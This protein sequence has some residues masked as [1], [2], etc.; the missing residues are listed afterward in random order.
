MSNVSKI[1]N[2]IKHGKNGERIP[3]SWDRDEIVKTYPYFS[4]IVKVSW[5]HNHDVIELDMGEDCESVAVLPDRTGVLIIQSEEK[6]GPDNAAILNADGTMRFRL[7]NPYPNHPGYRSA[8][9]F[10]FYRSKIKDGNIFLIV[11]M[12]SKTA[13]GSTVRGEWAYQLDPHTA[14]FGAFHEIR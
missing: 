11:E 7:K 2:F 1:D 10:S 8:D 13:S 3:E 6:F 5:Q 12:S 9:L 4:K 14:A